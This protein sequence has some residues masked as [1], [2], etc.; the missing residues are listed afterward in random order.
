MARK[1]NPPCTA[2][3]RTTL[4]LRR[5]FRKFF[6]ILHEY[7]KE[8]ADARKRAAAKAGNG[9]RKSRRVEEAD[10][11]DESLHGGY[12]PMTGENLVGERRA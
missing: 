5:R 2:K 11:D 8:Q 10:G 12:I 1:L 3:S 9:G 6:R 7:H 4:Y